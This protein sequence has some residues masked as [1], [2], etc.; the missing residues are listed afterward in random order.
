[1]IRFLEK[2]KKQIAK[3]K[4]AL[5]E[6]SLFKNMEK[7]YLE[8]AVEL[9]AQHEGF[10]SKPYHCTEGYL[11]IAYGKRVDYLQ[12]DKETGKKW[13]KEELK[14]LDKRL[15]HTFGWFNNS[16]DDVKKVVIDMCYNLGVSGFSKFK[17]TIYLFDTGQYEE[18]S[19][20]MLNSK[21]ANQVKTRALNDSL[22]I[23]KLKQGE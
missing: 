10:R 16:P 22:I 14:E 19:E 13:L 12:V 4:G 6:C 9:V 11:T 2:I 8:E 21:W 18:A 15:Q 3:I 5:S 1:M 23:K 17:K 20:E 7:N